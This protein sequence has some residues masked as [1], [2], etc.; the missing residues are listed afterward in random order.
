MVLNYLGYFILKCYGE[1]VVEFYQLIFFVFNFMDTQDTNVASTCPKCNS[2]LVEGVC[3]VCSA[4]ST[5]AADT[6]ANS[7]PAPETPQM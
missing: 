5:P 4:D 6:S 2:P 7:T 3:P 1:Y